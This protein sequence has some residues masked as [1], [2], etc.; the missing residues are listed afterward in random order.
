MIPEATAAVPEV[1][2]NRSVQSLAP[3]EVTYENI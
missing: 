1:P 3:L 2:G